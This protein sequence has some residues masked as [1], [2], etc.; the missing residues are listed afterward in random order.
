VGYYEDKRMEISGKMMG[1][2]N[3]RWEERK[4]DKK[5]GKQCN[6]QTKDGCTRQNVAYNWLVS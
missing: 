6:R 2:T 1:E 5:K 3:E 4:K